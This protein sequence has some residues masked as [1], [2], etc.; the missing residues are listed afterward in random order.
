MDVSMCIPSLPLY[1]QPIAVVFTVQLTGVVPGDR[2]PMPTRGTTTRHGRLFTS[3]TASSAA[4]GIFRDLKLHACFIRQPD[5][6]DGRHELY[7]V[8]SV[9][10]GPGDTGLAD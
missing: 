7:S 9:G 1:T 3:K 6:G 2:S 8:C 4:R 10:R 5:L